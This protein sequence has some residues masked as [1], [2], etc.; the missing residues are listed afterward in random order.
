MNV[1]PERE[2]QAT[3]TVTYGGGRFDPEKG[4]NALSYMV[5]KRSVDELTYSYHPYTENANIVRV[6]IK[7]KM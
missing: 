3:V 5:L 4:N 2:E 6:R 7:E 1:T